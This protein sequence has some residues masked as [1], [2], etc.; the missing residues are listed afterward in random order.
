MDHLIGG[1][2]LSIKEIHKAFPGRM[3]TY[4]AVSRPGIKDPAGFLRKA[5]E[6]IT[7]NIVENLN[8]EN[9][10]MQLVFIAEY[11]KPIGDKDERKNMN[12]IIKYAIIIPTT[13]IED[14]LGEVE[15]KLLNG[16]D[17]FYAKV[18]GWSLSKIISL[19]LRIKNYKPLRE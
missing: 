8:A 18:S 14:Y 9:I 4:S 6:L 7:V 2:Q 19:E 13:N 5:R 11:K 12:F 1:K 17:E 3:K 10:K 15:G 16:M